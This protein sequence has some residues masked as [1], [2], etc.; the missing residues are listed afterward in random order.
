MG[1]GWARGGNHIREKRFLSLAYKLQG[2]LQE[3]RGAGGKVWG[4]GFVERRPKISQVKKLQ[5]KGG[6]QGSCFIFLS[7]LEKVPKELIIPAPNSPPHKKAQ[8]SFLGVNPI[9]P[10]QQQQKC[11]SGLKIVYSLPSPPSLS[12]ASVGFLKS[13]KSISPAPFLDQTFSPHHFFFFKTLAFKVD[14]ARK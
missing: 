9:E 5:R 4:E 7:C 1:S 12:L 14:S 6:R 11:A 13:K 10:S 3:E 2:C 8:S